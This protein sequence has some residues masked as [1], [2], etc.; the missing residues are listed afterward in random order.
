MTNFQL[1]VASWK[2]ALAVVAAHGMTDLHEWDWVPHYMLWTLLPLPSF[3]VTGLFCAS[4]VAHFAEDGGPLVS[5]AAH[6]S[7]ALIGLRRG[8]DVAF[9]AMLSYLLLWHTPRHY[10]RHWRKGRKRGVYVA[11]LAT[12]VGLLYC[13]RLPNR[14]PFG[15][16]MQRIVIAHISHELRFK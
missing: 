1:E 12:A 15:D 14:L 11:A 9:K 6:A 3:M 8:A 7:V 13:R 16:L 10:L 2:P 4:S 5:L